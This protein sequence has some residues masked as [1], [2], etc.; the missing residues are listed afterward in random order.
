MKDSLK[1]KIWHYLSEVLAKPNPK[2]GKYPICPYIN[3]YK[4]QIAV[5]K[6]ADPEV[7][8]DNFAHVGHIF[9]LEAVVVYGFEWKH[10]A[11]MNK[12]RSLNKKYSKKDLECLFMDTHMTDFPL[13]AEYEWNECQLLIIQ[14]HST[15]AKSRK[16][17]EKGSYYS[18]FNDS[19]K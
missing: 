14:R 18:Y 12:V 6:N 11:G 9:E 2:L 17:L 13:P 15:L 4:H 3:K 5:V 1:Q 10:K 8:V 16:E 7:V 19:T